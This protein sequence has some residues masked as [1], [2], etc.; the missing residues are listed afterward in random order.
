MS[1]DGS[2][3]MNL[4]NNSAKDTDPCWSPDGTK[5]AFASD[6]DGNLEIYTMAVD[7]SNITRLTDNAA[8]DSSPTWKPV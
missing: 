7:G 8:E 3:P 2:N 5:I 6:R 1:A 4:T